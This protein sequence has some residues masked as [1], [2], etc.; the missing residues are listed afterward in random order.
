[1]ECENEEEMNKWNGKNYWFFEFW[2][3]V[4]VECVKSG[5]IIYYKI[6]EC[7]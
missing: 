1:M 4:L 6:V 3:I 7:V 2:Y 5:C